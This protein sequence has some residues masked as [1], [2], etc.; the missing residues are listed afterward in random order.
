[1]VP[2]ASA[3]GARRSPG[4]WVPAISGPRRGSG[5]CL[6]DRLGTR[7]LGPALSGVGD[8]AGDVRRSRSRVRE[9]RRPCPRPLPGPGPV[10]DPRRQR[11]RCRLRG[12]DPAGGRRPE[13]QELL[14]LADLREEPV[15]LRAAPG[16]GRDRTQGR[17]DRLR[18]LHRRHRLRRRRHRPGRCHLWNGAD[19]RPRPHAQA[20]R[21]PHRVGVR[22]RCGR[23][24]RGRAHL[25]MGAEP[26]GRRGRRPDARRRRS[27]GSRRK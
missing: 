12:T 24:S 18:G 25:R 15:A 22:R 7:R 21:S 17:I 9:P 10:P 8:Q 2:P 23:P 11:C 14:R 6:Q 27:G 16:K 4:S 5:S 26:R 19:R 20:I 13:V 3:L 1:M